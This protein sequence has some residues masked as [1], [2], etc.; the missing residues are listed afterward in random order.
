[1]TTQFS[2]KDAHHGRSKIFPVSAAVIFGICLHLV[3][4]GPC[5]AYPELQTGTNDTMIIIAGERLALE[6]LSL[7]AACWGRLQSIGILEESGSFFVGG[8]DMNR[9]PGQECLQVQG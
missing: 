5:M 3:T 2:L 7:R 8:C 1:M 9:D 6:C 4:N